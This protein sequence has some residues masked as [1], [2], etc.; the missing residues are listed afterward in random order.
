[1]GMDSLTAVELKNRVQASLGCTLPST[2]A[3]ECPNMEALVDYLVANPLASLFPPEE[4]PEGAP[5]GAGSEAAALDDDL[6]AA[7]IHRLMD[8]KLKDI[9]MLLDR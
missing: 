4:A 5:S 2:V 8:E 9:D 1:M 3:L 6:S 7:E